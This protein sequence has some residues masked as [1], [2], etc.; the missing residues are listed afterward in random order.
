MKKNFILFGLLFLLSWNWAFCQEERSKIRVTIV[1]M[2]NVEKDKRLNVITQTVTDTVSL[3]LKPIRKYRVFVEVDVDL[4]RDIYN[5]RRYAREKEVD[6]I[7]FGKASLGAAGEFI[8]EMSVYDRYKNSV[9][10]TNIIKRHSC[11][12]DP[13]GRYGTIETHCRS[14]IYISHS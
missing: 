11:I 4:Y 10:L 7:I 5:L 1:P 3:Y 8:F 12:L 13:T 9:V 6:N 2:I 14:I